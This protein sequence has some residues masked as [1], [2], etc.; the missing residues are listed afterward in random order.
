MRAVK[1]S[2]QGDAR[3]IDVANT[4]QAL[5]DAL[6]GYL[7]VFY[8]G[9][10]TDPMNSVIGLCDEDGWRTQPTPNIWSPYLTD[11]S[12]VVAGTI[13]LVR[14]APNGEFVDLTDD[15]IAE[16]NAMLPYAQI[17]IA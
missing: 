7:E 5:H 13:L 2:A 1:L 6:G 4:A 8:T 14:A 16:I 3:V 10:T 11:H 15:D 17:V 12:R 9:L